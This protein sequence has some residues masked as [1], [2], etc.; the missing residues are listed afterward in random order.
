M[1]YIFILSL[2]HSRSTVV[3][4]YLARHSSGISMGEVRRTLWPTEGEKLNR[5]DCSCGASWGQCDFWLRL[6]EGFAEGC[7]YFVNKKQVPLVDS[8]KEL[9]HYARVRAML[10]ESKISYCAVILI[11]EYFE[12][13]KSVVKSN[14]RHGR[15]IRDLVGRGKEHRLS[16]LRL[17]L[18]GAV[19]FSYAEWCLT[20]LRLI[21]AARS[22]ESFLITSATDAAKLAAKLGSGYEESNAHSKHIVRGNRVAR[23]RSDELE[24][25]SA[26]RFTVFLFKG[27]WKLVSAGEVR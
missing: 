9:A 5:V 24:D 21:W 6:D 20:N 1:R 2:D 26:S 3:D 16:T 25:F 11:R 10:E 15:G 22:G 14:T 27:F 7:D 12:W 23:T 19:P 18:R 8:S 17:L 13:R 4:M